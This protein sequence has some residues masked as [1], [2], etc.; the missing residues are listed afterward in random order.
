MRDRIKIVIIILIVGLIIFLGYFLFT[1]MTTKKKPV[2]DVH[3]VNVK[4]DKYDLGDNI[5]F[6]KLENVMFKSEDDVHDFSKWRVISQDR[7]YLTLY[8]VADWGTIKY[9][10]YYTELNQHRKILT[11]YGVFTG[12]DDEIRLLGNK[13][14][15]LFKCNTYNMTCLNV[16]DWIENSLTSVSN[17]KGYPIVFKDN[18]IAV[19][20]TSESIIY[21]PVIVINKKKIE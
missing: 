6:T 5:I 10:T 18:K 11:Q 4:K 15:E 9:N 21:H 16:P 20:A 17:N 1:K 13:E 12:Y 2:E 19:D 7:D 3:I 14:L 8:S